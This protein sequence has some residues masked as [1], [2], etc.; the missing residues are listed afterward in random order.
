MFHRAGLPSLHGVGQRVQWVLLLVLS[1]LLVLALEALHLSAALLLGPMLAAILLTAADG[2]VRVPP[3]IFI[4]SQ[5]VIGCMIARS[6][7]TPILAAMLGAWPLLLVSVLAVVAASV[8]L[9]WLLAR[10]RVLPGSTAVGG[11]LPGAASVMVLK[12]DA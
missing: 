11:S 3:S 5:G 9:G 6:L 2:T 10:L 12:A 7:T 1:A 8:L 4:A